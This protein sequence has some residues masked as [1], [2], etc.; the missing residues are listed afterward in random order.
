MAPT[1]GR[2]LSSGVDEESEIESLPDDVLGRIMG[3]VAKDGGGDEVA[4]ASTSKK[5]RNIYKSVNSKSWTLFTHAA[6]QEALSEIESTSS[7]FRLVA[8]PDECT[9]SDS[10]KVQKILFLLHNMQGLRSLSLGGLLVRPRSSSPLRCYDPE[11]PSSDHK[12]FWQLLA[13]ELGQFA[14]LTVLDLHG[15]SLKDEGADAV[16][17]G[18]GKVTG[19][20]MLNLSNTKISTLGAVYMARGLGKNTGLTT[21][22]LSENILNEREENLVELGNLVGLTSLDLRDTRLSAVGAAHMA[23]GLG[24]NEGLTS[25][26]L[27]ENALGNLIDHE[28]QELI[29]VG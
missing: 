28:M 1:E 6:D 11:Y 21:L 13:P 10:C 19:L 12:G 17:S 23:R 20:T 7:H 4:F 3:E 9:P 29:E 16:A 24:K 18:L 22:I 2:H 15:T 14:K 8:D 27:S 25:L 5:L 26:I